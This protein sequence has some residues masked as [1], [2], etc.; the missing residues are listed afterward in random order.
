MR[1]PKTLLVLIAAGLAACGGGGGV[2]TS[3][4]AGSSPAETRFLVA[5][6]TCIEVTSPDYA[7]TN[8]ADFSERRYAS[9]GDAGRTLKLDGVGGSDITGYDGVERVGDA[10]SP[11]A[12]LT[13][14]KLACVLNQLGTPDAVT[15]QMQATRALDGMQ[16]ATWEDVTA[17]WTY[18]PDDGLDVI[19]TSARP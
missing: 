4:A 16:T 13:M 19:L 1:R 17:R 10:D 15:A 14:E 2:P 18:H 12:G 7:D 11:P 3:M 6:D 8:F 5:R 9:L